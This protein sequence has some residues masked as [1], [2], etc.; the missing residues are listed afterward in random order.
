[1][2]EVD[3]ATMTLSEIYNLPDYYF[4]LHPQ[5]DYAHGVLPHLGIM[6]TRYSGTRLRRNGQQ[7]FTIKDDDPYDGMA[8][9][10]PHV[11]GEDGH[12][13]CEI[14]HPDATTYEPSKLSTDPE[15]LKRSHP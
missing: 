13:T 5:M 14:C 4:E 9:C 12:N 7:F 2:N 10:Y 6:F 3:P 15:M 8:E 1:M 11:Y